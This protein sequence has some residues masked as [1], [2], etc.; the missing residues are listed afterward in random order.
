MVK[1]LRQLLTLFNVGRTLYRLW[2]PELANPMK[3]VRGGARTMLLF[4]ISMISFFN[5]LIPNKFQSLLSFCLICRSGIVENQK[6]KYSELSLCFDYYLL[7]C[8]NQD[9]I[10]IQ[11]MTTLISD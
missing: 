11:K 1:I 4:L 2:T 10:L 3:E 9:S 6:K 8:A 7:Q 5:N